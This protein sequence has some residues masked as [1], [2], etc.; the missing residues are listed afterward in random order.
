M[1]ISHRFGTVVEETETLKIKKECCT[2]SKYYSLLFICE[3]KKFLTFLSVLYLGFM[4]F[5]LILNQTF[6]PVKLDK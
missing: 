3:Y 6:T 2:V 5:I 4:K 1:S